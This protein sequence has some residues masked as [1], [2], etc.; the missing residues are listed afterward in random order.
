MG[1]REQNCFPAWVMSFEDY[2]KGEM[3]EVPDLEGLTK[4]EA[5]EKAKESGLVIPEENIKSGSLKDPD[6][7]VAGHSPIAGAKVPVG[8]EMW[9]Y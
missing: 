1:K 7:K 6:V 3:I 5:V 8:S 2:K 4:E 9:I